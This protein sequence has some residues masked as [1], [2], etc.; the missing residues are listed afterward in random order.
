MSTEQKNKPRL[1]VNSESRPYWEGAANGQLL[2]RKC[3]SCDKVHYYPRT[4]C[5]HCFSDDTAF[6]EASGN[7]VIYSYSVTRQANPPYVI[8]Y[9]TI[10]EGVSMLT[11]IVDCDVEKVHIGQKVKVS[12]L[13]AEEGYALPVFTPV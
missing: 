6:I 1:I 7:G 10:D 4:I 12:F 13:E 5:P 8:A 11:N 2:I 9:V 3:N